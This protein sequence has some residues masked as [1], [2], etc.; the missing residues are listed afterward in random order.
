MDIYRGQIYFY[1]F[2]NAKDHSSAGKRPV[3]IIQNDIANKHSYTTIVVPITSRLNKPLLPT[4]VEVAPC[5]SGL[6]CTSRVLCGQMMTVDKVNLGE[7]V[8]E[9]NDEIM[10]K[11]NYAIRKSL[12]I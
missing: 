4:Q 8:G 12:S 9:L 5:D 1:N 7:W 10:R 6:Y 3:L 11:V 2:G